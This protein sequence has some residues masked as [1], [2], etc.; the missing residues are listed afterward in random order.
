M[1]EFEDWLYRVSGST[2][3]RSIAQDLGYQNT[4]L[5]RWIR[6]GKVP[7]ERVIEL[8]RHY[9]A[10]IWDGLRVAGYITSADMTTGG[11]SDL[12]ETTSRALLEELLRRALV[13]EEVE[14]IPVERIEAIVERVVAKK[15]TKD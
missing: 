11:G 7:A 14:A 15:L 6:E 13:N 2:S 10:S 1:T 4:A 3:Q 8:A 9:D 5:S 12:S